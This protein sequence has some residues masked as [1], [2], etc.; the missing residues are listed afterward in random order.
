M[1]MSAGGNDLSSGASASGCVAVTSAA[2]RVD[3]VYKRL[4]AL[5]YVDAKCGFGAVE[6]LAPEV[7]LT[8][9]AEV[10]EAFEAALNSGAPMEPADLGFSYGQTTTPS[11]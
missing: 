5:G 8:A 4:R 3:A 11:N 7:V 9:V 10:L 1:T 6:E 2:Q